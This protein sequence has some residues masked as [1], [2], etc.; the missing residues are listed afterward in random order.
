MDRKGN[1]LAVAVE[2]GQ[3]TGENSWA[4]CGEPPVVAG[5][6]IAATAGDNHAASERRLR[7]LCRSLV[8]ACTATVA[9]EVGSGAV[10]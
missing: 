8:A 1:I 6:R 5:Q 7:V 2:K 10:D 3:R 4:L 9:T